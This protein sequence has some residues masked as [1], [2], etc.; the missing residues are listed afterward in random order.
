M[1]SSY[2]AQPASKP[3]DMPLRRNLDRLSEQYDGKIGPTE[4]MGRFSLLPVIDVK[5]TYAHI[6]TESPS[7][8]CTSIHSGLSPI[9]CL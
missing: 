8:D 9:Q 1:S 5:V 4:G 2:D 3:V 7:A 6:I